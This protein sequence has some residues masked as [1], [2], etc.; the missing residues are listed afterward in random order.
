M[1]SRILLLAGI[2]NSGP[3][4]WQTLWQNADPAIAK[5]E[6]DRWDRPDRHA[7]VE[8]LE[9]ELDRIGPRVTLVAHSLACLLV[10]HWAATTRHA[11][12]AALLVSVP[13]PEGPAFPADAKNFSP[14]PMARLGFRSTVVSSSDDPY[15]SEQHMRRCARAW[16]SEFVSIGAR[17]HV[18]A[19]SRLGSWDQGRDLLRELTRG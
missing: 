12:D 18:N 4:H 3:L 1:T 2:H 6:H 7:W 8:D 19:A 10:A 9:R 5:L 13:D 16:G 14:V 15:G 17:G 11:I